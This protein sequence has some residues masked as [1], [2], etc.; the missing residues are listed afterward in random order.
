M[1][2]MIISG[3]TYCIIGG[4]VFNW[5]S[6]HFYIKENET[7]KE[8]RMNESKRCMLLGSM[9]AMGWIVT[10]PAFIYGKGKEG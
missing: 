9:I 4:I 5:L 3:W 8:Y 7:G 1:I 2:W 10:I 6:E